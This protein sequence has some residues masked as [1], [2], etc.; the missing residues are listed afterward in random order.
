[1]THGVEIGAVLVR[2]YYQVP[3]WHG[4]GDSFD[5]YADVVAHARLRK[6]TLWAQGIDR[7]R[8]H[9]DTRWA[10]RNPTTG[11]V[12]DLQVNRVEFATD[13]TRWAWERAQIGDSTVTVIAV[14]LD[15]H[16]QNAAIMWTEQMLLPSRGAAITAAR[17]DEDG[18][19]YPVDVIHRDGGWQ[20]VT[21]DN[22]GVFGRVCEAIAAKPPGV[23]GG[24]PYNAALVTVRWVGNA[25]VKPWTYQTPDND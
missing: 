7:P 23:T 21:R 15:L 10:M 18:K 6:D 9:I 5:D 19:T 17:V 13:E 25:D 20:L 4:F 8:V 24:N 16:D 12:V 14:D 1:M 22:P 3:E 11:D 2:E